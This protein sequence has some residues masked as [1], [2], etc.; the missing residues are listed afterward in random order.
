M[1][2]S[3]VAAAV[4]LPLFVL[5]EHRGKAPMLDLTIFQNRLFA[6]ASA[7]TFINGLA[8]F[9]LMFI[10][11]FYYQGRRATTRSWPGSS[12]RRWRSGCWSP[13][14]AGIWADRHGSRVLAALGMLVT[15]AG[16]ALMT[17]LQA[18]T[19]YW[20]GM[21]WLTLV[22]IGSGCSCRRTRRR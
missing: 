11:V 15:A 16:L 2:G 3:L 9:A 14:L 22:G 1:I 5:I 13:P 12:W 6:A 18:D 17:T 10:F 7:A 20:Q 8:R 19:P 4:L 21:L